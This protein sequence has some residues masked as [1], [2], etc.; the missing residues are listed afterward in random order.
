MSKQQP[1]SF[2]EFQELFST[3][4]AC[5]KHLFEIRWPEGFV[6]PKCLNKQ[7][8]KIAY[9]NLFE[10]SECGYQASV[11]AGTIFHKTRTPLRIWFWVIYL[12]TNDKRGVSAAQVAAQFN[13]SYPTA[14]AMLHKIRKAMGDREAKY[15]LDEI[16]E[17]DDSYFGGPGEGAKRGRGTDKT[18]VLSGLSLT[19]QGYPKFLKMKVVPNLT[20]KTLVEQAHQIIVSNSTVSTDLFRS[21]RQLAKEGFIHEPKEFNAKDNPDHLKW[22]HTMIANVKAFILGTYHGV[23]EKHLQAYLNEYC[24]R[25]NRRFFRSELFNR[26]LTACASTETITYAQLMAN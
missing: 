9:R 16:V 18:P 2:F 5:Q 15:F 14:W 7:A 11:T 1:I 3:E 25:F 22:L 23:S 8:Y 13:L 10:C 17:M 26:L 19:K 4:E 20:S 6:C 24:Y 12:V 21:Y